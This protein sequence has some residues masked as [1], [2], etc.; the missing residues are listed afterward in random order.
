MADK[1]AKSGIK[2]KGQLLDFTTKSF[3]KEQQKLDM[4]K[5]WKEEWDEH[6]IAT[7]SRFYAASQFIRPNTKPDAIFKMMPQE[8]FGR[9]TQTL[10]GHGYTG[11]YYHHFHINNHPHKCDVAC[12]D[13]LYINLHKF[14]QLKSIS[15]NTMWPVRNN[16]L[17]RK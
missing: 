7:T 12:S 5:R 13:N 1:A 8:P 3:V 14:W 6:K 2:K 16:Y 11:E 4:K 17:K 15:G 9:L 10:T